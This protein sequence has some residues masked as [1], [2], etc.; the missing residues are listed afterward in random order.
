MG[1]NSSYGSETAKYNSEFL[2]LYSEDYNDLFHF[3]CE[4]NIGGL[5]RYGKAAE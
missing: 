2:A 4:K 1:P 3:V 5:V